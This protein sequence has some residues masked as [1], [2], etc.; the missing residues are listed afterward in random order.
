[1]GGSLHWCGYHSSFQFTNAAG[2]IET[3][4]YSVV[5]YANQS[6][7]D[8]RG[9]NDSMTII[10]SHEVAEAITDPL[11]TG[12]YDGSG[13]EVGDRC[14]W[15]S[16]TFGPFTLQKVWSNSHFGCYSGQ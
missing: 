10:A 12:W 15:Q 4:K 9:V 6:G 3:V 8:S 5:P 14:S 11:G 16:Y 1:M 7:C 2:K 13:N